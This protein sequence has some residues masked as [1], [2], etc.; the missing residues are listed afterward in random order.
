MIVAFIVAAVTAAVF[1]YT[2]ANLLRKV[3]KLEAAVEKNNAWRNS[4]KEVV[5]HSD[6][7][8]KQIDEAGTFSSD[9]EI[10]WFFDNVKQLNE[11]LLE[12]SKDD[13]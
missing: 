5:Q 6:A 8:L 3:E 11:M 10:G 12:V 13:I 2:T 4:L 1:A 9:D 7:H